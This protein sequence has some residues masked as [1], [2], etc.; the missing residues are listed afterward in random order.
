MLTPTARGFRIVL[1]F[2]VAAAVSG[3]GHS[4]AQSPDTPKLAGTWT[5]TWKDRLG[6]THKHVLEVEGVGSKLAARELF[7][8]E[9]PARASNLTL[10]GSAVRFTVVR[11]NRRADYSGKVADADHINGTVTI[12][13]DGQAQEFVWKAERRKDVPKGN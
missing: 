11:D 7:D 6:E 13:S 5:W 1:G 12:T 8:D 2:L 4:S 10:E 9:A 3:G